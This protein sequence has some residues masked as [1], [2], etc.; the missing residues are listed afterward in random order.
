MR[1]M[2]RPAKRN[3]R[4]ASGDYARASTERDGLIHAVE[5]T[6]IKRLRELRQDLGGWPS[7]RRD[8]GAYG[9]P[10]PHGSASVTADS[11]VLDNWHWVLKNVSDCSE[12]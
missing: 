5:V 9:G 10:A 11:D 3:A 2:V 4:V 6:I 1:G 8:A 12:L 7:P